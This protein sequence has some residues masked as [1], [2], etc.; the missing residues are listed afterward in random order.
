MTGS[1]GRALGNMVMNLWVSSKMQNDLISQRLGSAVGSPNQWP[2][3]NIFTGIDTV[4]ITVGLCISVTG[5]PVQ[6]DVYGCII[7]LSEV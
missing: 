4:L 3:C 5:F 2:V 6:Q 7:T 1:S